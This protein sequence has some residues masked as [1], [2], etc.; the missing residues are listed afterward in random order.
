MNDGGILELDKLREI[1]IPNP[2][3]IGLIGNLNTISFKIPACAGSDSYRMTTN[4]LEPVII[5]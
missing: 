1:V 2:I 3:A 4:L 5:F